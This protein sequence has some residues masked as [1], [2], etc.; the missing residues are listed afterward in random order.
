MQQPPD[1]TLYSR[2]LPTGVTGIP[3]LREWDAVALVELRELAGDALAEFEFTVPAEGAPAVT[4]GE[5]V[6]PSALE[7]LADELDGKIDRPYE[8]RAVRY[9]ETRF[10]V[11]ARAVRTGETIDLPAGLPADTIEV[12]LSPDGELSA[13][14]DGEPIDPSQEELYGPAL[15]VL[16]RRGE[17]RFES[18]VARADKAEEGRWNVTVDPL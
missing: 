10:T 11:G 17:E 1:D 5:R 14:A 3:R 6:P 12:V 18:F 15:D 16:R 2:L 13:S 7:R 4:G 9:D 8:A